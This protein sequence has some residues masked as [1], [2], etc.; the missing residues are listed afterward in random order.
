MPERYSPRR[1]ANCKRV[2]A[3]QA[4]ARRNQRT[5][6]E[7]ARLMRGMW[8]EDCWFLTLTQGRRADL[9]VRAHAW[10]VVLT[11]LRQAWPQVEAWTVVEYTRERGVHLHAVIKGAPTLTS[12]WL[13]HIASLLGDGTRAHL[14]P[15]DNKPGLAR[16]LTKQLAALAAYAAAD[17]WPR[18]FRPVTTTRG[19]L[20]GWV[21]RRQWKAR[22]FL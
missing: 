2:S 4:R 20:P 16:Y 12:A 15:V 8:G 6:L 19:W 21:G 14:K 10:H 22:R 17:G 18:R 11:R 5:R 3:T 9:L 13:D 7:Y 1:D